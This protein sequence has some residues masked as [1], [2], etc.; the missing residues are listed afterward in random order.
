MPRLSII[1]PYNLQTLTNRYM[2][3]SRGPFLGIPATLIHVAFPV[4]GVKIAGW[5]DDNI[6]SDGIGLNG[7]AAHPRGDLR[8]AD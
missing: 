1:G 8:L 2:R 6:C 5:P 7:E 4:K 3:S